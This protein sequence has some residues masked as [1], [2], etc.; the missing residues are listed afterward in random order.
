MSRS[1]EVADE[2]M[3]IAAWYSVESPLGWASPVCGTLQDAA[4]MLRGEP[5]PTPDSGNAIGVLS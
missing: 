4:R 2:L 1:H 5:E 3:K